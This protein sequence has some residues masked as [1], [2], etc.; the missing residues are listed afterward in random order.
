[1]GGLEGEEKPAKGLGRSAG[2]GC[3]LE[4]SGEGVFP[5]GGSG[6]DGTAADGEV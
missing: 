3:V 2:G 1:M 4:A 6:R 5:G